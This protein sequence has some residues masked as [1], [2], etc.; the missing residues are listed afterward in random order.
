M[1]RT[2]TALV[3]LVVFGF[4]TMTLHAADAPATPAPPAAPAKT[5]MVVGEMCGGCVTKITAR[6]KQMPEI[7]TI[8]CDIKTKTVTVVHRPDKT[9][10]P[11]VLWDV[12][13]QIG[14]TPKKMTG[15]AGT[16]TAQPAK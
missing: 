1:I 16:F 10:S 2:K 4:L 9:L 6:L 7:A 12:M 13:A 8:Q 11:R 5:Q 15:P 3:A 14:K